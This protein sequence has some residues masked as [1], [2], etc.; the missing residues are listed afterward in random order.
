M[1]MKE[2]LLHY[3]WR[4]RRFEQKGLQTTTHEPIEIINPGIHN[5]DAGPDF[6]NARIRIGDTLWAGHVEMHLKA[7][8]WYR[9]QHQEDDAYRNVIL[10]VVL[11]EDVP[12]QIGNTRLP[13]LEMK[14]LLSKKLIAHYQRLQHN[15]QWI[16]CEAQFGDVAEATKQLWLDRLLVERLEGRT[17]VIRQRLELLKND[18]ETT[19]YQLLGRNFGFNVNNDA[20]EALV[21]SLPLAI[22]RKHQ[23][24]RTQFEALFFGQAGLLDEAF[25]E[26]YPK[27]LK[28][29]YRFLA[30]KYSL[31]PIPKTMWRFMRLR[32]ANFPT[33]RIAQFAGLVFQTTHLFDKA[34][35]AQSV[36]EI[37]NLFDISVSPYWL[38]HYQFDKPTAR[39]TKRLGKPSIHLLIINTISPFLFLYGKMRGPERYQSRALAFLEALPPEDNRIIRRWSALGLPPV[40][41][42]QS[43]ALLQL[44]K[45]YCDQRQC[46]AC[47]IGCS[48]LK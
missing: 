47:A 3:V 42:Y 5:H 33:I 1:K 17:A 22:L 8:D 4:L 37:E 41:A 19:F 20:F 38:K 30:R 10:H 11:E 36:K 16:P 15:S 23:N 7:S 27:K 46:L 34:L 25:E 13:C 40:S 48:I 39:R 26:S 28:Q 18:W 12:V 6:L 45:Q 2:D 14:K 29:E 43:Q 9:H 24:S 21:R 35:S 32:P 44:K 31:T